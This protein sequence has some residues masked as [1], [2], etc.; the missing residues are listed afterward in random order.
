V[1]DTAFVTA[2]MRARET[3]RGTPLFLDPLASLLGGDHARRVAGRLHSRLFFHGVTAR[4]AVLDEFIAR[5]VNR[6]GARSVVNLGAGLDTRPYRLALPADLRWVEVD[7]PRI[8]DYK[9]IV[10]HRVR[11]RCQVERLSVDLTDAAARQVLV[12]RLCGGGPTLILSEGLVMYLCENKVVELAR[13]LITGTTVEW[14]ALD[15]VGSP[16]FLPWANRFPR[17]RSSIA[18]TSLQFAPR[19]GA[20]F[21]RPLGWEP[22]DIRFSWLEQRRLGCEPWL[23][24]ATWAASPRQLRQALQKMSLFVLLKREV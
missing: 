2:G 17:R 19:D 20:G 11:P 13:D 23:M 22:V 8:V 18:N 21:F 15:L 4:T 14:W 5:T 24:R 10:L 7:L 3:Q 16:W 9:S 12:D 6:D 1:A